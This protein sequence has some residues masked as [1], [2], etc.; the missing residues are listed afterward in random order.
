M[1]ATEKQEAQISPRNCATRY[2]SGNLVNAA[3]RCERSHLN[4]LKIT[5]KWHIWSIAATS[6]SCTVSEILSLTYCIRRAFC[7]CQHTV[8]IVGL[9]YINRRLLAYLLTFSV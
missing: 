7:I 4:W 2:V 9:R 5:R 3:Q 8:I 1:Y 6:I